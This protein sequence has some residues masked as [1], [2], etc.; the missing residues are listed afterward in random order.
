MPLNMKASFQ[1]RARNRNEGKMALTFC[2]VNT[3][4]NV[5]NTQDLTMYHKQTLLMARDRV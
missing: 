1:L 2:V 3:C 4:A 5:T